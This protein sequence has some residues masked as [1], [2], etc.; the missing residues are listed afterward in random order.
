MPVEVEREQFE[1]YVAQAVEAL[2]PEFLDRLSNLAFSVE[3]WARPEDFARTRS[4]SGTT[5]LGVYRGVPLNR[6]GGGYGMVAP[7]HIVIFRG[8]LQRLARD[9]Q[10]LADRIAH[11]VRHEVA[12]H[13]GISDERLREIDAY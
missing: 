2:P 13:F 3:D 8:P 12:H 7:D 1:A 6:R 10:D 5:L 4:P 9:E 11:V